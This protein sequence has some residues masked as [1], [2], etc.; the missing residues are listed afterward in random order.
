MAPHRKQIA[1]K[2][3]SPP[4]VHHLR[5][6]ITSGLRQKNPKTNTPTMDQVDFSY[7]SLPYND[8]LHSVMDNEIDSRFI[9]QNIDTNMIH[10]DR[11][12][13]IETD[14]RL[15]LINTDFKMPSG[16]LNDSFVNIR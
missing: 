10:N 7:T 4:D 14:L 1:S 5:R 6:L 3:Q 13:D 11:F 9:Y 12:M 2:T 15:K 8:D 16:K